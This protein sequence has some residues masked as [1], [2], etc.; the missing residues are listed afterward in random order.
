MANIEKCQSLGNIALGWQGTREER[1]REFNSVDAYCA[2][3]VD[4]QYEIT[5]HVFA[6]CAA[7][8]TVLDQMFMVVNGSIL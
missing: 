3:L 1:E 4:G 2:M 5:T 8:K 6:L 7:I